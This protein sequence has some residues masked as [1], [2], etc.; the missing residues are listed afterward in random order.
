MC[1]S[2]VAN[3]RLIDRHSRQDDGPLD[4]LLPEKAHVQQDQIIAQHTEDQAT[5]H[6]TQNGAAPAVAVVR[7]TSAVTAIPR[8]CSDHVARGVSNRS[9]QAS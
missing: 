8:I 7:H 6:D 1:P 3:V 4:D 9:A 2:F 5:K